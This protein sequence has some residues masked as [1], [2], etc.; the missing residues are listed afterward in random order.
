MIIVT[1]LVKKPGSKE[2]AGP[3]K[4]FFCVVNTCRYN[5]GEGTCYYQGNQ[6]EI[7]E[8]HKDESDIIAKCILYEE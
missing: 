4:M 7:I 8:G 5:D 2:T 6:R 3:E 1:S